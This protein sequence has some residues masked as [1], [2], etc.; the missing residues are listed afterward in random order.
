MCRHYGPSIADSQCAFVMQSC[1][2]VFRTVEAAVKLH[3][4]TVTISQLAGCLCTCFVSKILGLCGR[5]CLRQ[6]RCVP[7]KYCEFSIC[8]WNA[9]V[10]VAPLKVKNMLISVSTFYQCGSIA[11]SKQCKLWYR[12]E[13]SVVCPSVRLSNYCI[14]SK[15][16]K[17]A[18]WFLHW[19][20][21]V[22]RL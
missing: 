15:R 16:T 20:R 11:T 9:P 21:R 5:S 4:Q 3:L 22:R 10:T 13:M 7:K 14:V 12:T 8:R 17:L 6:G 18:L 1:V 19:R 2:T